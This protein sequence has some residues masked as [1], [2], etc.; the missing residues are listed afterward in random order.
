MRN[1]RDHLLPLACGLLVIFFSGG[2]RAQSVSNGDFETDASDFNSPGSNGATGIL[3]N[4]FAIPDWTFGTSANANPGPAGGTATGLGGVDPE[5]NTLG[6]ADPSATADRDYAWIYHSGYLE[7]A[8]DF[9][10]YTNYTLTVDVAI[11]TGETAVPYYVIDD[12]DATT[13]APAQDVSNFAIAPN[14]STFTTET[15]TF[16]TT[17]GGWGYI[18]FGNDPVELPAGANQTVDFTNFY[19]NGIDP[20]PPGVPEPGIWAMLLAGCGVLVALGRLQA[21]AAA[22]RMGVS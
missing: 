13:P 1:C 10:P 16:S 14:N 20:P 18:L 22:K 7:Q 8:I 3:R 11:R 5:T 21:L 2:A 6:P 9:H 17:K 19:L 12:G 15:I 4:P